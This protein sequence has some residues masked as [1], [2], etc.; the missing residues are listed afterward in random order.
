MFSFIPC[1]FLVRI[2]FKYGTTIKLK[3]YYKNS[4]QILLKKKS[5]SQWRILHSLRDIARKLVELKTKNTIF[6]FEMLQ[7]GDVNIP[8]YV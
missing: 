8:M 6:R 4:T 2:Q 1:H 3:N 5:E 7:N